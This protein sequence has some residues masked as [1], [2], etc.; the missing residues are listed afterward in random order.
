MLVS[1]PMWVTWAL[2]INEMRFTS[3]TKKEYTTQV[4][5]K[6]FMSFASCFNAKNI[7]NKAVTTT[8]FHVNGNL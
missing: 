7:N 8:S 3:R 2:W 6:L 5:I 1:V 4:P